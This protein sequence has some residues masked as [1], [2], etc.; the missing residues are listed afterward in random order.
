MSGLWPSPHP[1]EKK[2]AITIVRL[3]IKPS[4]VERLDV[5]A[6]P[7]AVDWAATV[8]RIE[9]QSGWA[10]V[11]LGYEAERF[12]KPLIVIIWKNNT[13]PAPF[14]R[15]GSSL[16]GSTIL[17]RL[18]RFFSSPPEVI[19]LWHARDQASRALVTTPSFTGQRGGGPG[20]P[21]GMAEFIRLQGPSNILKAAIAEIQNN[22]AMFKWIRDNPHMDNDARYYT[23]N[24]G[25]AL[26]LEDDQ[27][28]RNSIEG[29][30]RTD[31]AG[32]DMAKFGYVLFWASKV[33]R[34]EFRNPAVSDESFETDSAQRYG[35]TFWD[36]RI[37]QP[38][39]RLVD[40][41]GVH[42][43]SWDYYADIWVASNKI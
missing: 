12:D 40:E 15:S 14:F 20:H 41:H 4:H 32:E 31:D 9:S 7:L 37:A 29:G 30:E 42:M 38:L 23:F 26:I 33:D 16:D 17:R 22:I 36:E 5:T 19:T 11:C 27:D 1:L 3:S 6:K 10:N 43:S 2:H 35:A 8:E 18:R 24:G 13:V 39:R 25:P 34:A 28:Y 21:G